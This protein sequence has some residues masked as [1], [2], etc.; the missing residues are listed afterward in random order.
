MILATGERGSQL[1][2]R[3]LGQ[4]LKLKAL[5][6]AVVKHST[7]IRAHPRR[8]FGFKARDKLRVTV[9]DSRG[10]NLNKD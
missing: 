3:L 5:L 1:L 8:S 9:V 10:V 7:H 6:K 2:L 4:G